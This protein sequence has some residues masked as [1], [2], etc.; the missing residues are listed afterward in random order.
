M[1]AA[2]DGL[3]FPQRYWA[4]LTL[5]IGLMMAVLDTAIAN[6]A[7]PLI[8]HDLHASAA[9]SIWVVNAYQ[10][11]VT[12]SLL[13]LA[14]LG[15]IF[16]YRRV[17]RGGLVVF[18]IASFACATS[19]TLTMLTLARVLQG[20]GA[21]GLMSVNSALFRFT[22]PRR[23]LGRAVAM[24][25]L[26][27]AVSSAT[28]PT[29]AAVILSVATWPWLFAVNVPIGIVALVMTMRTL[30]YNK[31]ATHPYDWS[32]AAISALTFGL[33][34]TSIDGA[35]H[36]QRGALVAIELLAAIGLGVVLVRRQA[37]SPM[38]L[39]PV[40]LFRRPIFAL[41]VT[42]SV[43]SFVAQGLALVALPFYLQDVLGYSAVAS[44][45]L[46]TPWPAVVAV[47]API[48]G[49]L[50]DRY[51]AGVLGGIGLAALTLGLMLV[52]LLPAEPTA[53][54]IIWRMM[55]C[56]FGFG[57][58]QS[59]NNR[60][61]IS[62]APRERSG[63]AGAIQAT[64]RLTGQTIG[65]ALVALIFNL[66][67]ASSGVSPK[68]ALIVASGFSTAAVAASLSRLSRFARARPAAASPPADAPGPAG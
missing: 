42:T 37:A 26:V 23:Q 11:A 66:A 38:P 62:S 44:G 45:L 48:S 28:G 15:D 53:G 24:I 30:P 7:L 25:A 3:P 22:Y 16:G 9:S 67:A 65:A 14:S 4:I 47:V 19:H 39:L 46:L 50:A 59:P 27:V 18:T 43:C 33:L 32:S 41:S 57:L 36:G 51:P 8:A 54:A 1:D 13:P 52:A 56:G 29:V 34:I 12:I 61:M 35:G 63:G 10:L 64:A 68:L 5:A 21:A 17:Y 60:A 6:I 40:D 55:I 20:F 49:R 58:F 2:E 31:P